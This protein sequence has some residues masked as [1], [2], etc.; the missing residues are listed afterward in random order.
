MEPL[1]E[2]STFS[3]QDINEFQSEISSNTE[4]V[5]TFN[6]N[7]TSIQKPIKKTGKDLDKEIERLAKERK[8]AKEE[9]EEAQKELRE[10]R[11]KF[12]KKDQELETNIESRKERLG[13]KFNREKDKLEA[14]KAEKFAKL[15]EIIGEK[16]KKSTGFF[17]LIKN[18][19]S[20]IKNRVSTPSQSTID[21]L[22]KEQIEANEKFEEAR[23]KLKDAQKNF[24]TKEKEL[25]KNVKRKKQE[26]E[27]KYSEKSTAI[28]EK[29]DA[30]SAK[31][32]GSSVNSE[33]SSYSQFSKTQSQGGNKDYKSQSKGNAAQ[34]NIKTKSEG[35]FTNKEEE[36]RKQ[37]ISNTRRL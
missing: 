22:Q 26:I 34:Q 15:N 35:A 3:E 33:I 31:I 14:K 17:T 32:P 37:G 6:Q 7:K 1:S 29:Y 20:D 28:K 9:L 23:Q 21:T 16:P 11:K 2:S 18:L 27:S 19:F 30:K 8:T 4:E 36:R 10:A 25:D 5:I 13:Y 24:K 12:Q